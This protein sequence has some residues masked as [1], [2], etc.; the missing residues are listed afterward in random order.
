MNLLS[1]MFFLPTHNPS[2]LKLVFIS[3]F[4]L[5]LSEEL[6][7]FITNEVTKLW[8]IVVSTSDYS[9]IILQSSISTSVN[10]SHL[11]RRVTGQRGFICNHSEDLNDFTR[12]L[13]I[14]YDLHRM[15]STTG[16]TTVQQQRTTTWAR[17]RV[18]QVYLFN[19]N[20][21]FALD[22]SCLSRNP[23]V[24]AKF[25][26]SRQNHFRLS[27]EFIFSGIEKNEAICADQLAWRG[28]KGLT[29]WR[30]ILEAKLQKR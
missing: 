3:I 18:Q 20:L 11:P 12:C 24:R 30:I 29:E 26:L 25:S 17:L 14:S 1:R 13:C 8:I 5:Y 27:V 6:H 7:H 15:D 4:S 28:F 19:L 23:R 21:L 16:L 2:R 10:S 9:E 22:N